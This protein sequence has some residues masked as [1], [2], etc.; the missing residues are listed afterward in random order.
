MRMSGPSM[1]LR[2]CHL[3]ATLCVASSLVLVAL[4][5]SDPISGFCLRILSFGKP[6]GNCGA[7]FG[8]SCCIPQYRA[9]VVRGV[10]WHISFFLLR[11]FTTP[12]EPSRLASSIATLW[13]NKAGNHSCATYILS[14]DLSLSP[15]LLPYDWKERE[16][17][18]QNLEN[19]RELLTLLGV[20]FPSSLIHA[21]VGLDSVGGHARPPAKPCESG[22]YNGGGSY[23][24]C[25]PEDPASPVQVGGICHG[26]HGVL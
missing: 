19:R 12:V 22:V 13:G 1:G 15:H 14:H 4:G 17:E 26:V 8:Y 11:L 10:R 23:D 24:L 18:K 25:M 2:M 6:L 7:H 3:L 16:I 21:R 5:G 20:A 9:R